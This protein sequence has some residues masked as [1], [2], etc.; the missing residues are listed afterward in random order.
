M[1]LKCHLALLWRP[2]TIGK[3]FQGLNFSVENGLIKHKFLIF[4]RAKTKKERKI[5]LSGMVED[6]ESLQFAAIETFIE[7]IVFI[8]VILLNFSA[9]GR[10]LS[11][12]IYYF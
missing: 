1:A 10:V 6:L 9:E 4:E 11:E 12:K 2:V 8:I 7:F 3:H 5:M